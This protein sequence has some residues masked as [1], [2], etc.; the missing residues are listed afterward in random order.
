M[1]WLVKHTTTVID[2]I[3]DKQKLQDCVEFVKL[4]DDLEF[5]ARLVALD[6]LGQSVMK[7]FTKLQGKQITV[8]AADAELDKFRAELQANFS[9]VQDPSKKREK[10]LR[11]RLQRKIDAHDTKMKNWREAEEHRARL[12]VQNAEKKR[13]TSVAAAQEDVTSRA[14]PREPSKDLENYKKPDDVYVAVTS[15]KAPGVTFGVFFRKIG[16]RVEQPACADDAAVFAKLQMIDCKSLTVD[17]DLL[18][19]VATLV[20]MP[21]LRPK[22]RVKAPHTNTDPTPITT[23]R[24]LYDLVK[25]RSSTAVSSSSSS[26][27]SSQAPAQELNSS[28]DEADP[29]QPLSLGTVFE[30]YA[31]YVKLLGSEKRNAYWLELARFENEQDHRPVMDDSS[32]FSEHWKLYKVSYPM[33][34]SLASCIAVVYAHSCSVEADFSTLKRAKSLYQAALRMLPI[35]GKYVAM[36][37]DM[38][39]KLW[40][41]L[42]PNK[43]FKSILFK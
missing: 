30:P 28:D 24:G 39:L 31:E 8:Q 10:V 26:S 40:Q 19:A 34:A 11:S 3:G 27:S 29:R 41:K 2:L 22:W 20:G 13:K 5:R 17:P 7:T 38:L 15:A 37:Y 14:P 1:A 42:H 6:V 32:P 33:L 35:N 4:R 9:I 16:G 36:E 21:Q 43:T 23:P 12:A 18:K 25:S